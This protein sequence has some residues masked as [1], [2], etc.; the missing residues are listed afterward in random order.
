VYFTSF[1]LINW[2][3]SSVLNAQEPWAIKLLR[4]S[5]FYCTPSF[6]SFQ[7][8]FN[9]DTFAKVN[10]ELGFNGRN[11]TLKSKLVFISSF[12]IWFFDRRNWQ[13][14]HYCLNKG[15]IL[16]KSLKFFKIWL[17]DTHTWDPIIVIF[18][19]F[20]NK[21]YGW[22]WKKEKN[23]PTMVLTYKRAHTHACKGWGWG[24]EEESTQ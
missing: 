24:Q 5:K 13:L 19:K 2:L 15:I 10:D 3:C 4:P 17:F 12:K 7:F 22:L 23:R 8:H 1:I 20:T 6:R 14:G 21:L 16:S 9:W 18:W 11:F